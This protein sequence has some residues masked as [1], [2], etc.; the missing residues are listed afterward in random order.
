VWIII[1]EVVLREV[2]NVVLRIS[3]TRELKYQQE[4]LYSEFV[5]YDDL[6]D[7]QQY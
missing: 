4:N 7:K 2:S 5:S 3:L 1:D 6:V